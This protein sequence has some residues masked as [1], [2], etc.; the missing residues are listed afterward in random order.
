[1]K[2][3]L[4]TFMAV[5]IC[6]LSAWG[7]TSV[8]TI[9]KAVT[10]CNDFAFAKKLL[11]GDG[12]IYDEAKSNKSFARFYKP[13][14]YAD[15]AMFVEVYKSKGCSKIEKCVVTF[16]NVKYLSDL[17]RV[18]YKYFNPEDLSIE[19]FQMLY[20][21]GKYAM[22]FNCNKKGWLI[23]TFFRYDQEVEFEHLL[24]K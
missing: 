3:V 22:G 2:K 7:Q 20:E 13:A 19:P 9:G 10:Q 16:S 15:K 4:V 17:S 11:T 18:G 6:S 8:A 5:F 23:A 14:Q 21:S 12:L 1:M 24:E